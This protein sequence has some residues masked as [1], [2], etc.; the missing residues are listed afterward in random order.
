MHSFNCK[1]YGWPI[2]KV[3]T[4]FNHLR[5]HAQVV[6]NQPFLTKQSTTVAGFQAGKQGTDKVGEYA[7]AS[8]INTTFGIV[9]HKG[10]KMAFKLQQKNS[11][12][13]PLSYLMTLGHRSTLFFTL[14]P[15]L[16]Y[17]KAAL[18]SAVF[19]I[20]IQHQTQQHLLTELVPP[21]R[22][23]TILSKCRAA[24]FYHLQHPW[25]SSQDPCMYHLP[26]PYLQTHGHWSKILPYGLISGGLSFPVLLKCNTLYSISFSSSFKKPQNYLLLQRPFLR[27]AIHKVQK[28]VCSSASANQRGAQ[29]HWT[30][31]HYLFRHYPFLKCDSNNHY[32]FFIL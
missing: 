12:V 30:N 28:P 3:W 2:Y 5:I 7:K 23:T 25:P 8:P 31:F 32:A 21:L 19:I 11:T 20:P 1:P 24:N 15:S 6:S 29:L 4:S 9:S 16:P 26:L 22:H 17:P 27:Q 18:I 14:H 13:L 10:I